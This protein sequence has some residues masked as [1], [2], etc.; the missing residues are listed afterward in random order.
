MPDFTSLQVFSS[1]TS[2]VGST[3]DQLARYF[4]RL[5]W[6][7]SRRERVIRTDDK[8]ASS[9][10]QRALCPNGPSARGRK[11]STK[12]SNNPGEYNEAGGSPGQE[13]FHS[14]SISIGQKTGITVALSGELCHTVFEKGTSSCLFYK[15][16][17]TNYGGPTT[18]L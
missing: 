2:P 1:P 17:R 3:H 14:R 4:A 9:A 15:Q 16:K 5:V 11:F 18:V 6:Q 12:N 10:S 7:F 8:S 13:A